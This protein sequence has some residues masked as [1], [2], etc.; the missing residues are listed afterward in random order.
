M[1]E[2][3]GK[4]AYRPT[5]KTAVRDKNRFCC[6]KHQN[7]FIQFDKL[8]QTEIQGFFPDSDLRLSRLRLSS[9]SKADDNNSRSEIYLK[10]NIAR[11]TQV[12]KMKVLF[13]GKVVQW[14]SFENLNS[15]ENFIVATMI[16]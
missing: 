12:N 10:N 2:D 13:F 9:F 8:K 14:S 15:L 1:N 7:D 5:L 11:R 16:V 6:Q 3:N 4:S